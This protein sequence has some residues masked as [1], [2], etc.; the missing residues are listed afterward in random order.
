MRNPI[1]DT[2][3]FH[4][5]PEETQVLSLSKQET[6]YQKRTDYALFNPNV[7]FTGLFFHVNETQYII[8]STR[9]EFQDCEKVYGCGVN[10]SE[11]A[12]ASVECS[13]IK[14]SW[15][16]H[17]I[18]LGSLAKR[19]NGDTQQRPTVIQYR[20]RLSPGRMSCYTIRTLAI[21]WRYRNL[22]DKLLTEMWRLL[23]LWPSN[24]TWHWVVW[25]KFTDV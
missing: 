23:C 19:L 9:D 7:W 2:L 6:Q 25:Y 3:P 8:G 17:E 20:Q 24:G 18:L 22:T 16:N 5:F 1:L 13:N 21:K 10:I 14:W 15:S 12:V 11:F 4:L